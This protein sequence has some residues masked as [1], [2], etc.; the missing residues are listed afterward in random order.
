MYLYC[1]GIMF[2]SERTALT[3]VMING[4]LS[5]YRWFADETIGIEMTLGFLKE[6]VFIS[7]HHRKKYQQ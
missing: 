2:E 7:T 5:V 4:I 1:C 6:L 3:L